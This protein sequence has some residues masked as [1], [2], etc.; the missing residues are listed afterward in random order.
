MTNLQTQQWNSNLNLNISV[1][2]AHVPNDY[3]LAIIKQGSRCGSALRR[4]YL[5]KQQKIF[6]KATTKKTNN[7]EEKATLEIPLCLMKE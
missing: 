3:C 4:E 1:S 2:K 7:Q 5:L 6:V